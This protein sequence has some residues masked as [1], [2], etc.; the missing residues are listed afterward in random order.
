MEANTNPNASAMGGADIHGK[1]VSMYRTS[2]AQAFY[3]MAFDEITRR[4]GAP[5]DA[6]ILD[7]GCGSCAKSVLLA[8]RGFR[9]VGADFRPTPSPSPVK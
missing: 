2:E 8:Q 5:R 7:A 6:V 4:L 1:W 9:V 3:E